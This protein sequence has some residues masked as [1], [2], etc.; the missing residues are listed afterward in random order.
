MIDGK[1]YAIDTTLI[2]NYNSVSQRER[3]RRVLFILQKIV[4]ALDRHNM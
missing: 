3:K 2:G 1:R 4:E